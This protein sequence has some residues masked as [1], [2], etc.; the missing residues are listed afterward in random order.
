MSVDVIR[1]MTPEQVRAAIDAFSPKYVEDWDAWLAVSP[2]GRAKLFGQTLRKWQATRPRPSRRIRAE[3]RHEPP[4]LDDLVESAGGPLRVL[5]DLTVL[6]VAQ[7]SHQQDEAL[8]VMWDVFSGLTVTGHASCVGITKAVLLL[9]DGRIGPAF[10]SNVQ[11]RLSRP[12]TSA[13][14]V[15]IL[16][17]VGH[18]IAAF[19]SAH[20]PLA[21]VVSPRFAHLGPGRLY[22]MILGPR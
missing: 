13:A 15:R 18:D 19:E 16:E 20:G 12:G 4:Y 14:W 8:A 1:K 11:R 2:R 21:Q 22:D 7:R 10:D 3:A 6:N 17:E 9:T 5:E